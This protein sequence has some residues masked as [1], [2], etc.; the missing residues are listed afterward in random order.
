MACYRE[1][2]RLFTYELTIREK[3]TLVTSGPYSIVRHPSY[4]AL[5]LHHAQTHLLIIYNRR[6]IVMVI[7]AGCAIL[8]IGMSI[9]HLSPGT[10]WTDSSLMQQTYFGK[11]VALLWTVILV[12]SALVFMRAEK[13]DKM[14]KEEFGKEW[15]AWAERTKWR[16]IP[17]VA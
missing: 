9:Y 14:L 16:F 12:Y 11:L 8:A 1:L 2:G 15:E 4:S 6:H 5:P 13:E 17:W 3:H 10:Y 7:L